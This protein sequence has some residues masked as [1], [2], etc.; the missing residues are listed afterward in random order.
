MNRR[1]FAGDTPN[2]MRTIQSENA[3]CLR[4]AFT[5]IELLVVIAIIAILAG[6]LLPALSKAKD[7][8]QS[9]ADLSNLKQILLAT[10]MYSTDNADYM[11]HPTWGE[12]GSAPGPNG[13]A[14][15][16]SNDGTYPAAPKVIPSV[17]NKL[18]FTNQVPFFQ[19]G[20]LGKHLGNSQ[21]IMECPKDVAQR[22]SGQYKTWY[23]QR[24]V[25]LTAYTFNGAVCG[26]S[27]GAAIV[28]PNADKGG[29]YKV[30]QFQPQD[31]LVWETDETKPYNFNDAGQNPMNVDE[32]VSQR[33]A[34]GQAKST[35]QNVGG[36]A[37]MGRFGSSAGFIKWKAFGDMRKISKVKTAPSELYCGPGYR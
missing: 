34:G 22:G 24:I 37:L 16:T 12:V 27:D 31:W 6:M 18:E 1:R 13:W 8:A 23:L 33:H 20:L 29:T 4:R 10:A 32:G 35:T 17:A 19:M 5:L 30:T 3:R 26:Y 9:T 25:K 14:Y 21:K 11:P 2:P 7:K 36:G 15:A 28:C